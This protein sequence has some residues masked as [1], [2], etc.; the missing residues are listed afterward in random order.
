MVVSFVSTILA[1]GATTAP[2]P[3]VLVCPQNRAPLPDESLMCGG[4]M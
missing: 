1:C 3:G 2:L 4:Y